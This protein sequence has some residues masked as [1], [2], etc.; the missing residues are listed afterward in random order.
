MSAH[1]SRSFLR[2]G[3][4]VLAAFGL[5]LGGFAGPAS[6]LGGEQGALLI[7][8]PGNT[9]FAG[10][11]AFATGVGTAGTTVSY[12][13]EVKNTGTST[14]Q[15]LVQVTLSGDS[16]SCTPTVT[17]DAGSLDVT[18]SATGS[19]GYFTVPVAPGKT[20][21]LTLKVTI[22]RAAHPT[23]AFEHVVNLSDTAGTILANAFP[24]TEVS[25]TTGSTGY[26]EFLTA[27]GQKSVGF[28]PLVA[29]GL[30]VN[31]KQAAAAHFTLKL[32]N[33]STTPAQIRMQL[34][35]ENSCN[36]GFPIVAKVGSTDITSL[37]T[38]AGYQTKVLAPKGSV[39]VALTITYMSTSSCTSA[40]FS[41]WVA[42]SEDGN[43]HSQ[44]IAML[45]FPAAS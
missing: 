24:L 44:Q 13:L 8:G 11:G 28:S 35:S 25:A 37:A 17:V 32:V 14:S 4:A 34:A 41:Q 5:V 22:P 42:F 19:T 30:V 38:G 6:A 39:S 16:C 27:T 31:E 10:S 33:D 45:V 36:P 23:D 9:L 12:A 18:A 2:A 29:G 3:V 21:P 20:T 43:G 26:D 15:Y 1:R 40:D 7:H